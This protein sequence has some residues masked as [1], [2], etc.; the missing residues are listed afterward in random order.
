MATTTTASDTVNYVT[1]VWFHTGGFKV[2]SLYSK[3]N[4]NEDNYESFKETKIDDFKVLCRAYMDASPNITRNN[5]V[6]RCDM[7][8]ERHALFLYEKLSQY[9]SCTRHDTIVSI[10]GVNMLEVF[11]L[12]YKDATIYN[13]KNYYFFRDIAYNTSF[14]D[15]IPTFRYVR[16]LPDAVAPSKHKASDS[17]YDLVLL[18]V[19]KTHGNVT[20][21]DTGIQIAPPNGWYFDMVGRS[22][23]S[24]TGYML[25]NNVGIIDASYRGNIIV[26]LVKIDKDA[27]DLE[28]PA[29]LVQ[30]IPRKVWHMQAQECETLEETARAAGGF[31]SSGTV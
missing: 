20:F 31:G 11:D 29:K 28:L 5:D 15:D 1:A 2:D 23:I 22:S 17:G 25:A 13:T 30:I 24:K 18:N 8:K 9:I 12:L 26:A 6:F 27:P 19:L 21:Y 16:T 4:V 14:L 10:S 7:G 3:D